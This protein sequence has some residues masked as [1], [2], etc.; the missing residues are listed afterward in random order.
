MS[1]ANYILCDFCDKKVIYVGEDDRPKCRVFCS[2]ECMER[3]LTRR[4]T[5]RLQS[6]WLRCEKVRHDPKRT[7]YLHEEDDDRPYEVDGVMYCGRC[8]SVCG[9][10]DWRCLNQPAVTKADP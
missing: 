2:D 3:Y 9:A 10:S 6:D 8:H 5:S 7:G 4:E 1:A